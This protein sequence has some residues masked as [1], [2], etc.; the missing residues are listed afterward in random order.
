MTER[1]KVLNVLESMIGFRVREQELSIPIQERILQ[2]MRVD[3]RMEHLR[4]ENG[5]LN[6][7]RLALNVFVVASGVVG[8]VGI[9]VGGLLLLRSYSFLLEAAL[10]IWA[11]IAVFLVDYYIMRFTWSVRHIVHEKESDIARLAVTFDQGLENLSHQ[12]LAEPPPT[13]LPLD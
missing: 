6:R 10:S 12:M 9:V 7:R 4:E 13:R 8:G 1:P 5:A 11:G 3:R 2:L